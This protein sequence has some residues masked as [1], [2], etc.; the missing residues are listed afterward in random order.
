MLWDG[1][2]FDIAVPLGAGGADESCFKV[3]ASPDALGE[4]VDEV[5]KIMCTGALQLM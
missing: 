5:T 1:G 3:D 2:P 4:V